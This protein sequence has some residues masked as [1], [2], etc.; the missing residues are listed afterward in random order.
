MK[1]SDGWSR[2]LPALWVRS[3]PQVVLWFE[4]WLSME[5]RGGLEPPLDPAGGIILIELTKMW[6][7]QHLI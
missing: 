7:W 6:W 4:K 2:D 3:S 5:Q 1:D